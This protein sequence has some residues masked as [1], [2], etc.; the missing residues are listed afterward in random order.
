MHGK[1]IKI[2]EDNRENLQHLRK[3]EA[4]FT[5]KECSKFCL[6]KYVKPN[7]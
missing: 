7:N 2:I 4:K 3:E 6:T 5:E 1:Y